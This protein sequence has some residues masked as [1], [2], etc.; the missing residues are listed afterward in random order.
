M[1]KY[2]A[3]VKVSGLYVTTIV[4]AEGIQ[5]AMALLKAQYGIANIVHMPMQVT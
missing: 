1:H 3:T 2:K 5:Q 4:F